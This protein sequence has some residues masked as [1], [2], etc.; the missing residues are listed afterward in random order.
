MSDKIW[1][2][3]VDHFYAVSNDRHDWKPMI[4][5]CVSRGTDGLGVFYCGVEC[6]YEKDGKSYSRNVACGEVIAYL[7]STREEA[8]KAFAELT[9]KPLEL[10]VGRFYGDR[11]LQIVLVH[12]NDGDE[13][14]PFDAVRLIDGDL[15]SY[16]LKGESRPSRESAEDLIHDLGTDYVQALAKLDEL[17]KPKAKKFRPFKDAEEFEASGIT[18]VKDVDSNSRFLITSYDDDGVTTDDGMMYPALLNCYTQFNGT[19]CGVEVA[20]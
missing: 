11:N 18:W 10:Q 1:D 17:K 19:P 3:K 2:Y 13:D 14:V 7:G 9:K 8:D 20:E 12:T 15:E 16:S 5:R 6:R 4:A